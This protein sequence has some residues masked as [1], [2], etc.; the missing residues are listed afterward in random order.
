MN[1][2]ISK[3]K[4]SETMKPIAKVSITDQVVEKIKNRI[5][6][7]EF[8]KGDKLPPENEL[9]Q[10]LE[11]G[12]S[13]IR[14]AFRVLQASGFVEVIHGKGAFVASSE[15]RQSISA[16]NWFLQN[17]YQLSDV[18]DVRLAIEQMAVN[19]AIARMTDKELQILN[20]VQESFAQ[21]VIQGR[22]NQMALYDEYFHACLVE[23]AHNPLLVSLNNSIADALRA[24]RLNSFAISSNR[25]NAIGPHQ[26]I[27]D[28]LTA[29][30]LQRAMQAVD[31]HINISI[32]DI[33]RIVSKPND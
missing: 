16:E 21:A 25:F 7:G 15:N 10:Q 22:I 18:W 32:E 1:L 31:T 8:S 24:Y 5:I 4:G 20:K 27:I 30:D 26:E 33:E 19:R 14:E 11:V 9:C 28:A 3:Q 2:S 17:N 6:L 29:R 12:R 23:G 13:T